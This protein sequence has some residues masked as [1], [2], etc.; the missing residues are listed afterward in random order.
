M[1]EKYFK[2]HQHNCF[3]HPLKNFN[4]PRLTNNKIYKIRHGTYAME[5]I[6]YSVFLELREQLLEEGYTVNGEKIL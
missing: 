6:V 1:I 2:T 4:W 3:S 5:R